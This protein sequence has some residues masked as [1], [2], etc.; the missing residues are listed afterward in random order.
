MLFLWPQLCGCANTITFRP[1]HHY[2]C[3]RGSGTWI[4]AFT[5]LKGTQAKEWEQKCWQGKC[6]ARSRDLAT[7]QYKTEVNRTPSSI[8]TEKPRV[9]E[10]LAPL[11][12]LYF[13]NFNSSWHCLCMCMHAYIRTYVYIFTQIT[14]HTCTATAENLAQTRWQR[15]QQQHHLKRKVLS[16]REKWWRN[17]GRRKR[18]SCS[19]ANKKVNVEQD[20]G[21]WD[22]RRLNEL[23]NERKLVIYLNN[24]LA[25]LGI[26]VARYL[27]TTG[28]VLS[29]H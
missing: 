1:K 19:T 24:F 6:F 13:S 10:G 3:K 17:R 2:D 16:A 14:R 11:P 27:M 28:G 7:V 4:P 9:W 21:N 29:T 8:E 15:Q 18:G 26:N 25:A 12:V 23:M 20:A 5:G 22:S